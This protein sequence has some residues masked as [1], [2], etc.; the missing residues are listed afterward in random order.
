MSKERKKG[1]EERRKEERNGYER[2]QTQ[3]FHK[4]AFIKDKQKRQNKQMKL[5]CNPFSLRKLGRI[6]LLQADKEI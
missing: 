6:W 4:T 2:Q 3:Y 1:M 5:I